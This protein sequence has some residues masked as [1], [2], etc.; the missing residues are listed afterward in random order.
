MRANLK[1][2]KSD[3]RIAESFEDLSW[4]GSSDFGETGK[5]GTIR[6]AEVS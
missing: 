6:E 1:N 2:D 3:Q 4:G 5:P